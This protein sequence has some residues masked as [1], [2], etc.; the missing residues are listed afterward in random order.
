M[1][2]LTQWCFAVGTLATCLI[3]MLLTF[4]PDI[5]GKYEATFGPR[6]LF[7]AG[8]LFFLGVVVQLAQS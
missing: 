8:A 6:L 3:F 4:C 2:S 7:F 1:N 5:P